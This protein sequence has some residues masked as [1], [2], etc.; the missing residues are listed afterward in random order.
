MCKKQTSVS[1]SSNESEIISLDAG[2][3]MDGILAL[4]LW[5]LVNEL[6]HSSS[7]QFKKPKER[8]Q[9]DLLRDTSSSMHTNIQTQNPIQHDDLELCNVDNVSS[10]VKSSQFGA[11]LYIFEDNEAVIK[12]NMEGRSPTK[13]H[14]SRT[15]RAALDWLFER[16]NL[17]PKIQIKYVHLV[18]GTIFS[19]CVTSAI[20]EQFAAPQNFSSASC[21]KTMSKR[22]QQ[23]HGEERIVA[24][25]KPTLHLVSKTEASSSTVLSPSASNRP[26]KLRAPSQKCLILQEST[27]KPVARDSNQND[28]ASS[29]HVWQK[30]AERDE[31]SR[32]LVATGTNQDLLNFRESSESTRRLAALRAENSESINGN[33]TVWPHNLHTSTSYVSHLE[34]VF[35]NVQQKFG[36]KPRHSSRRSS[37]WKRLCGDFTLHQ[38]SVSTNI[39]KLFNASGKLIK[40]QNEIQGLY[41]I[42][43]QQQTWQ[44]TTLLTEKGSSVIKCRNPW[45]GLSIVYGSKSSQSLEEDRLASEFTPI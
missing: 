20:S 12:M 17:D 34:N 40:N 41:V 9:G 27:G 5:D 36:R 29:S 13:T 15:H 19:I 24:K 45:V 22:M 23:E 18:S 8:V 25:S 26:E 32:R 31:S 14:E 16:I 3:R 44:R 35:S 21:P 10:H 42:N 37:S 43:W 11:M 2:L 6:F 1:H 38:K 7:N 4:D 28:A 30:D 39:E 33:D